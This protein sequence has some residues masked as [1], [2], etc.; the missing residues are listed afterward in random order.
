VAINLAASGAANRLSIGASNVVH[1][2]TIQRVADPTNSSGGGGDTLS[3]IVLSTTAS[4]SSLLDTET[5]NGLQMTIEKCSNA[6]TEAG[7]A[8]AYS[9]R[10][11]PRLERHLGDVLGEDAQQE[12]PVTWRVRPAPP[13][14]SPLERRRHSPP[15]R[16]AAT[17]TASAPVSV[18]PLPV[19][20][21]P[22]KFAVAPARAT[23]WRP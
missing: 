18:F 15:L 13:R 23:A 17:V 21:F 16:P 14:R 9:Q 10:R 2:D 3:S 11:V 7:T 20:D 4:P 12:L 5:T 19:S 1:G 6:W 22:L 8:P